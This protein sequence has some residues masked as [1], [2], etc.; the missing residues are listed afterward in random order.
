MQENKP[1]NTTRIY[2]QNVNGIK[3]D[4]HGG[5]WPMICESMAAMHAD[6][7]CL[8]EINIDVTQYAIR[9]QMDRICRK[10]F[11]SHR[12]VASTTTS[13]VK[14][15]YKPGGT[16][17]IS[18]MSISNTV[19]QT[20]RDRMGRWVSSRYTAAQ[21]RYLTIIS[22][23][24]VCQQHTFG[25]NTATAQQST[26]L[27]DESL[28]QDTTTRITARHAFIRDLS[29]FIRQRQQENDEIILVGDFNETMENAQSGMLQMATSCT[30]TD[31]FTQRLGAANYPPTVKQG[32]R[33]VD[34]ALVSPSLVESITQAG[35]D[36]YDYRGI[37]SDHRGFFLDF[38]T[39][40]LIGFRP[41]ATP[42]R[43]LRDFTS[44]DP[45]VVRKYI[46]AKVK[47]LSNHNITARIEELEKLEVPDHHFAESIDRDMTRAARIASK[48][49]QRR[50]RTPWSPIF[51]KAWAQIHFYKMC[52]SQ[53]K[54][55]HDMSESIRA[56][57]R[58]HQYLP[59][60]I[61]T[62]I[63]TISQG[64]QEA[65]EQLKAARQN[66][67]SLR[68]EH[69]EARAALYR[70]LQENGKAKIVERL[71]RAETLHRAYTKLACLRKPDM[72]TGL[73]HLE[74]PLDPSQDPKTCPK[75]PTHWRIERVPEEI[76]RMIL[77]R[78]QQHFGQA[79]GTPFTAPEITAHIKF[80]G[81]GQAAD[82]ILDG[83]FNTSNMG[84]A[85]KA[86]I[87][88][89]SRK[90][91][92]ELQGNITERDF[93]GKLKNWDEAT[94]TSPSGLHLGH[95]HV[96]WREH[97]LDPETDAIQIEELEQ[98]RKL[99]IRI[100]V[101]LI[102]YSIK[103]GYAYDRWTNV[104]NIMLLKDPNL[105][106]IHRLRVIHL[107]EADYNLLLA[108]K[109]R[110]TMYHAEDNQLLNPNLYGSR[111]AR[112]A[113][114]PVL[115]EVL[116][117][118]IYRVSM[119]VGL[120][121]DLDATSCYDRIIP[122]IGNICSR[123]MGTNK[124]VAILNC[125]T[126]EATK[127][128]LKTNLGISNNWYQH[129]TQAPIYGTGQGSGNS[130]HVWNFI[131]SAL[132]DAHE[133]KA[134][135]ATFHSYSKDASIKICMTGYVDDCSQRLNDFSAH[136]QPQ[137]QELIGRMEKD[138][139]WWNDLLWAS[140]GAL[141]I[142]K[143]S[144]HL[145]QSNWTND[146]N[147]FLEAT[148]TAPPLYLQSPTG[149]IQVSRLSNYKSHKTLGHYVNP[150]GSMH[151]QLQQLIKQSKHFAELVQT[152]MLTKEET[153]IM[154]QAIYIPSITYTLSNTHLT[155]QECNLIDI[156]IHQAV[157]P[158]CGFHRFMASAIR[159]GPYQFGGAGF[160]DLYTEQTVASTLTALKF[161]RTP[162]SQPGQLLKI[163]LSWTQAYVGT[164]T[165]LWEDTTTELPSCPSR[166]ILGIRAGLARIN[167]Q[168]IMEGITSPTLREQDFHIMD[169]ALQLR[170]KFSSRGIN[171]INACRRYLQAITLADISND[172][173]TKIRI[174]MTNG[175]YQATP[176]DHQCE[177]FN[178]ALPGP[179]AWRTWR[180]FLK[181]ITTRNYTLKEPLRKWTVEN[182]ECRRKPEYIYNGETTTLYKRSG[183]GYTTTKRVGPG[184]YQRT[185]TITDITNA[186]SGFPVY[187]SE[188]GT[189]LLPWH[190]FRPPPPA[191]HPAE[192]FQEHIKHLDNWERTLLESHTLAGH[193]EEI[194]NILKH[195]HI[196]AASDG[197]VK[198][199]SA[200]FGYVIACTSTSRRLIRGRGP[201][202]G[203]DPS[204]F[205]AEAYGALAVL[206]ML[207]QLEKFTGTR[208]TTSIHHFIDNSS[209][210]NRIET[211]R[212]QTVKNPRDT[213]NPDHD[214]IAEIVKGIEELQIPY[215][216]QWVRGH[217]D[218]AQPRRTLSL[219]AQLN[220]EAD[221]QGSKYQTD[222]SASFVKI[223]PLPC[224]PAY[225]WIAGQTI[226]SRYKTRIREASTI[227]NLKQYMCKRFGWSKDTM[228]DIDWDVYKRLVAAQRHNHI[229]MVKHF[230]AISP[231][232]HFAN[233]N[234]PHLPRG[235]PSCPCPDETNDHIITC[236]AT[237]RSQWR[238]STTTQLFNKI[239][240]TWQTD[241]V[242]EAIIS[243]GLLRVH[244]N[245]A[246]SVPCE[247]YHPSYHQL[248]ESQNQIGWI[249]IY[250]G[251]WSREWVKAHE[252]YARHREWDSEDSDGP[253]WVHKCGNFLLERW[254]VL[255]TLR[256]TERHGKDEKEKQTNLQ[257]LLLPQLEHYYRLAQRVIPV[258]K[259]LLFPY[260]DA[261]THLDQTQNL[262]QLQEWILD[263]LPRAE[264]SASQACRHSRN[265]TQDIRTWFPPPR[266]PD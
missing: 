54:Y 22:A 119:K 256:N 85:S 30:L 185:N 254:K 73:T 87:K 210:V 14:H 163:A 171:Q 212:Q 137:A 51:A 176:E 141:E 62:D 214:V 239:S 240:T 98:K 117:N 192:T 111:P 77:T 12:L 165:F 99:L 126:L 266:A 88:H 113:Q 83:K 255:W 251:K 11:T 60:E 35:Y 235:C 28:H 112:S 25:P 106:R 133:E 261:T 58:T 46:T 234:Q 61:P 67:E 252:K 257:N 105:P 57:Q 134:I 107:Y 64:L 49:V 48:E 74:V 246:P 92:T 139:Q 187:V 26:M 225:L 42:G 188:C 120:N 45:D 207:I 55:N 244:N 128:R 159:Y 194:A 182:G 248:I 190:N 75:D 236:P 5:T 173:G 200:G 109:W 129:S 143:C 23:Y 19:A 154:Y 180:K 10:Y 142:P 71:Q 162:T 197:T 70:T 224:S 156:P 53:H 223:P 82:L 97:G 208:L 65:H 37:F 189:D 6:V 93:I 151:S 183:H 8:S 15:T 32:S 167:G 227:P 230:H 237:S 1:Q 146:G 36:A 59:K 179:N 118:E 27:L 21:G 247:N 124:Q 34:F 18:A 47:E 228:N 147:P 95:Y 222:A 29:A 115:L 150:H 94:T 76:E 164:S 96:L 41:T 215:T 68:Q 63:Y 169:K 79:Q 250:R 209:V 198:A 166:W 203:V 181:E 78:N 229:I 178:Q 238:L 66:A 81:S 52:Q 101:S 104:V 3:W 100:H 152:N 263:N 135:G 199:Q 202:F 242:L 262:E 31:L 220:C 226:T 122:A 191:I 40:K 131:C 102:N 80:D 44:K 264:A 172:Q 260:Q 148:I 161:L 39:T 17:M 184:R 20:T 221:D 149:Q 140:G 116:Q 216:V 114:E 158:R 205:R 231:T 195:N 132:F 259:A 7:F 138:A 213:L 201:A 33:R 136:P 249:Q 204:S 43:K 110:E 219:E 175:E 218:S 170:N 108:V 258:D 90:T 153:R 233:R 206:R 86:F 253:A 145:I 91:T 72:G 50:Y 211:L 245:L 2:C 125:R 177:L 56:W 103:F 16:A 24:Q 121:K 196:S 193:P 157:L 217:Q 186:P 265:G 38:D 174:E 4:K 123:R 241:P 69:L 155:P 243:D 9:Q 160:K 84:N 232:G 130:P 89:M 127:Y 168:I 144:Y 13:K